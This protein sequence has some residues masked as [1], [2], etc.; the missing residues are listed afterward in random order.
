[1]DWLVSRLS[2]LDSL[3]LLEE[4]QVTNIA[5]IFGGVV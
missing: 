4:L 5:T 2:L 3:V 1:M